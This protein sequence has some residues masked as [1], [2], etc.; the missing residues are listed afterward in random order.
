[1]NRKHTNERATGRNQGNRLHS[2]N[3]CVPQDCG[4]TTEHRVCEHVFNNDGGTALHRTRAR[5]AL[6]K[7]HRLKEIQKLVVETVL[8]PDVK[9]AG[10]KIAQLDIAQLGLRE[11]Y[12]PAQEGVDDRLHLAGDMFTVWF[13]WSHNKHRSASIA[14]APS[15]I[16]RT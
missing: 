14:Y 11:L 5:R 3:A 6:S 7:V 8:G 12:A 13:I 2:T 9:R 1:M 10:S 4:S 15:S 16:L